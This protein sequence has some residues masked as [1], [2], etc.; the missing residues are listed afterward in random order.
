MILPVPDVLDDVFHR[1][2]EAAVL[3]HVL[4]H[5]LDGVD[6]RGMVPPAELFPDGGHGHLGD[7]PDDV[8]GDLPGGGYL[9]RPLAGADVRRGDPVGA[10]DFRDDP[11]HRDGD[12]LVV[13]ENVPDSVLGDEDGGGEPASCW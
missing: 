9:G 12:G 2:F 7:L 5:L 6:H 11:F 10:G 4:F 8:H 1:F 13:V 3:F